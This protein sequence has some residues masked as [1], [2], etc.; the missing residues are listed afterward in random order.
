MVMN[1]I[2]PIAA[3]R[4]ITQQLHLRMYVYAYRLQVMQ[5]F[6]DRRGCRGELRGMDRGLCKDFLLTACAP[7]TTQVHHWMEQTCHNTGSSLDGV[8]LSRH[9]FITGWSRPV[10]TQ[11]HH[12]ME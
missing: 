6:S 11:V 3:I 5:W 12:W 2:L 8:D 1:M 4:E 7:V 10:T 9:R